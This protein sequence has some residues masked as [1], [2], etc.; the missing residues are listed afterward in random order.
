MHAKLFNLKVVGNV[1]YEYDYVLIN[2]T[3]RVK[4]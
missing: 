3:Q 1:H 4:Q 2:L